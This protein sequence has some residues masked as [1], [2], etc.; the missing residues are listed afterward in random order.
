MDRYLGR[1]EDRI[2]A[3]TR[4]VVGFLF[5]CHGAQKLFGVLGRAEAV[6]LTS[7]FGVAGVIELVGGGLVAL[8]LFTSWAA[9]LCSGQMAVAYFFW[10]Q[11]DALFPI[12]NKGEPAAL[13]AW[14]F[15]LIAARGAGPWSLDARRSGTTLGAG[16]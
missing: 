1:F 15:L 4:I 14:I 16:I 3:L 12:M 7:I 10:H 9:L 5:F 8:G 13:Y 6:P 11:P 2:Y